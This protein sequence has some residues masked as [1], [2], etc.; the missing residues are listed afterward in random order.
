MCP[1]PG[2]LPESGIEPTSLKSPALNRQEGWVDAKQL[3]YLTFAVLQIL[4][5]RLRDLNDAAEIK[6]LVTRNIKT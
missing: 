5:W 2:D 3:T 6:L 4:E 1:H